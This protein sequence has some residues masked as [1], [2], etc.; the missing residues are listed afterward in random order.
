M[1]ALMELYHF[2]NEGWCILAD[3]EDIEGVKEYK[4]YTLQFY[5]GHPR[6]FSVNTLD[7]DK[8]AST[9]CKLRY[10]ERVDYEGFRKGD[11]VFC[12]KNCHVSYGTIDR[13]N[14]KEREVIFTNGKKANIYTLLAHEKVGVIGCSQCQVPVYEAIA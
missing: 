10:R 6:S 7:A 14:K 9:D 8:L 2:D 4:F 5:A 12:F 13:V 3:I 1:T 11:E